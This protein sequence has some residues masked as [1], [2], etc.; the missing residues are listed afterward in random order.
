[1]YLVLNGM[2]RLPIFG[3]GDR[4]RVGAS[5]RFSISHRAL[6]PLVDLHDVQMIHCVG[7]RMKAM[8]QALPHE[9]QGKWVNHAED[10]A[11]QAHSLVDAGYVV[12]VKGSKGC[13]VCL[14]VESL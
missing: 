7:P 4:L 5:V 12:V 6:A 14:V 2:W 11:V 13:R 8:W 3:V 1:M 9:K 10:L